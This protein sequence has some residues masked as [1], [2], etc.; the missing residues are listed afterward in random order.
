M[1]VEWRYWSENSGINLMSEFRKFQITNPKP[2]TNHKLKYQTDAFCL[3][4]SD[5]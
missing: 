4:I 2:Q 3:N 5:F 1:V